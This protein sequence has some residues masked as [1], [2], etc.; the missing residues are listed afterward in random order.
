MP[1]R[2]K[3]MIRQVSSDQP[4]LQNAQNSITNAEKQ[5]ADLKKPLWYVMTR[6]DNPGYSDYSENAD[7][8]A[9]VATVFPLFFLMVAALVCLTTMT[10]MVEE[11][12]TQIG[13]LKA[14]GY[15]NFAITSKYVIYA[16]L[17]SILGSVIG[18]AVGN[19]LF[20]TVIYN[21]Y[22]VM[23]SLPPLIITFQWLVAVVCA[24]AAI[25]CTVSVA[26]FT[27]LRELLRP[28]A[29]LMRPK[30]P[31][32]GKRIFLEY[33]PQIW[34]RMGF[35]SKVTARNILRY[36]ARFLMSVIGIAGCCA[37]I[38][39]GLGL[40]DSISEIV[41]TQFNEIY[42]YNLIMSLRNDVSGITAQKLT[43]SLADDAR[44]KQ[45]MLVNQVN[46]NARKGSKKVQIYLF[47]PQNSA[48]LSDFIDLR[49]RTGG[50]KVTL[51]NDGVVITEKA[52]TMLGVTK[53]STI[54][55]Q[56]G[57]TTEN[58]KITDITE[59]YVYHYVYMSPA[60]YA[61]TFGG[62]CHSTRLLA[63]SRAQATHL[64]RN[65]LQ[66]GLNTTIYS[67]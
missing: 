30:A 25:V 35:I 36:K 52:A 57:T 3:N 45:S 34:S 4:Q 15:G 49:H 63:K 64:K 53:G 61:K 24:L 58:V 11:K 46:M 54:E 59:N 18:V 66:T 43:T 38:L 2:K 7:R 41:P 62:T 42:K 39:A 40:K 37:L 16:S 12:R 14:L 5:L 17:A 31:R 21:A 50:G 20:P 55:L 32:P 22:T 29:T 1:Q 13:T 33:I 60:L 27:S 51:G 48:Q 8:I 9:A 6:S 44:I 23:Y 67:V 56:D 28:S 26:L 65:L 10:R 47:V 19:V